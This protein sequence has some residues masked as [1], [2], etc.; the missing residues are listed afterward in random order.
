M[1]VLLYSV[2]EVHAGC[3]GNKMRWWMLTGKVS[4]NSVHRFLDSSCGV[5][6]DEAGA[7]GGAVRASLMESVTDFKHVCSFTEE[8]YRLPALSYSRLQLKN[9]EFCLFFL[10]FYILWVHVY[11]WLHMCHALTT[12]SY[13]EHPSESS[14]E[15]DEKE[16]RSE[17]QE[18][19]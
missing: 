5:S 13:P 12:L 16:Q 2:M 18:D 10:F 6:S 1:V 14:Q 11:T 9:S 3:Y 8:A 7:R 15:D 17:L 19:G 4:G